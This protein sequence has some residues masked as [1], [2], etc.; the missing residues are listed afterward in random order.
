MKDRKILLIHGY[1]GVPQVFLWLKEELEKLGYL[2]VM[3]ELPT[4]ENVRYDIWK[5]EFEKYKKDLDGELIV[6]AHSGGN[7][8]I[9]KYLN[10]NDLGIKLYV[11]LA[12]FSDKF[13][14][15][16]RKDLDDAVESLAPTDEEI[17]NFKNNV[18]ARYAIYSDDDHI[19]PLE[20]LKKHA[21]NIGAE[22]LLISGIGHMGKKSNLQTLP[23]VLEIIGRTSA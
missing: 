22:H 13:V 10:E 7:P 16:G 23:Q 1:N 14:T 6:V 2:V 20:I 21:D 9:I 5:N 4:Q 18:D 3:P 17:N 19:I 12:G 15:E 11:G 8:F